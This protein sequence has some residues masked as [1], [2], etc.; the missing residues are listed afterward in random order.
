RVGVVIHLAFEP[1]TAGLGVV[2]A[3]EQADGPSAVAFDADVVLVAVRQAADRVVVRSAFAVLNLVAVGELRVVERDGVVRRVDGVL[4][5]AG[6]AGRVEDLRKL[7]QAERQGRGFGLDRDRAR[8]IGF[9]VAE[10]RVGV[11]QDDI[12]RHRG[13]DGAAAARTHNPGR[14]RHS[15]RFVCVTH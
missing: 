10:A 4:S 15:Y 11:V 8:G 5:F 9:A 14:C 7:H 2:L 13:A 12:Y 3:V 6:F 1:G